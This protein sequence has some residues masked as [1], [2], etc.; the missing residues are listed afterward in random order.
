VIVESRAAMVA[1]LTVRLARQDEC[2]LLGRFNA[3]L[4]RDERHE[5]A[6]TSAELGDRMREWLADDYRACLFETKAG[7]TGYALFRD[8]P[9]CVHLRHFFVVP[10]CRG[11]GLGRRAFQRLR[12]EFFPVDKRVLV[13]VLTWN[14]SGLAFWKSLGFGERYLGL[15]LPAVSEPSTT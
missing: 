4:I 8:L 11:I 7:P 6:M 3:Q 1:D 2:A 12:A 10:E 13:E 15:Q 9:E 14:A 5:N